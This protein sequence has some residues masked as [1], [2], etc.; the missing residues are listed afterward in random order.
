[1]ECM[2]GGNMSSLSLRSTQ[3]TNSRGAPLAAATRKVRQ[4]LKRESYSRSHPGVF[5]RAGA[6]LLPIATDTCCQLASDVLYCPSMH[7][8]AQLLH[9][10]P[11]S[12]VGAPHVAQ[13]TLQSIAVLRDIVLGSSRAFLRSQHGGPRF[14]LSTQLSNSSCVSVVYCCFCCR[15][16]RTRPV[17]LLHSPQFPARLWYLAGPP[18]V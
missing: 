6:C 2:R 15:P 12:C 16:M 14:A 9:A 5:L 11:E 10:L 3:R 7:A 18:C 4:D 13:L 1:M 8:A 17:L